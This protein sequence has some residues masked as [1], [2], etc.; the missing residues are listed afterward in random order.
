MRVVQVKLLEDGTGRV[1]IHYFAHEPKGPIL[2]PATGV[3]T[4]IGMVKLG[5]V[6]GYIACKPRLASILPHTVPG[7]DI[8]PCVHTDDPRAA[9]CPDCIASEAWKRHMEEL[10]GLV[11]TNPVAT[12]IGAA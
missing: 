9:T 3:T 12:E 8:A 6:R 1:C 11:D 7:G 2:T 4:S 10:E 5:G